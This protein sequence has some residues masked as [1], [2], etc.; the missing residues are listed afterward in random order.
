MAKKRDQI[1]MS[2]EERREFLAG[3]K[4][5]ILTSIGADGFP[6]S[7]P[8]WYALDP[9]GNV[10]ITTF[11]KSQKVLNCRRNPKAMLLVED[12]EE[13][14]ELRGVMIK[15]EV[16]VV[17]DTEL[18][19]DTMLEVA[20]SDPMA[21]QESDGEALRAGIRPVAEKRVVLLCKPVEILSF[22]HRKLGGVY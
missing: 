19:I 3:A 5:V 18:A 10:R 6:H 8:M 20:G 22:D 9:N 1:R 12:G 16:E 2:D 21:A 7:V 11:R 13:Y 14:A 4:T 17:D 15:A